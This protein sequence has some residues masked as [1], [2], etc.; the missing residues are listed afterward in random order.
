MNFFGFVLAGAGLFLLVDVAPNVAVM[1]GGIV[2][3]GYTLA[4]PSALQQL[5]SLISGKTVVQ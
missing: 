2:L 1:T 3:L 4:N 5:S